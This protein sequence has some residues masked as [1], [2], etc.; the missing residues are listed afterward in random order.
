M[1][2]LHL[3]AKPGCD[4]VDAEEVI[5]FLSEKE[6]SATGYQEALLFLSAKTEISGRLFKKYTT[7]GVKACSIPCE[8]QLILLA[9][10]I[11]HK[12]LS[13]LDLD[14]PYKLKLCNS[15][16]K[17]LENISLRGGEFAEPIQQLLKSTEEKLANLVMSNKFDVVESKSIFD[18]KEI[19]DF[20]TLPITVLFWEGP[21]ARAYLATMYGCGYKPKKILNLISSVDLATKKP[22]AKYTPKIL[23]TIIC[24]F[25]HKIK[26]H[27]W[28][29]NIRKQNN[30]IFSDFRNAI[31]AT[32][33][34][35]SKIYN[36]AYNYKPLA[37]YSEDVV[38]L[39]ITD[40][41]D[42]V[43]GKVIAEEK[44]LFLFTGGGIVPKSLLALEEVKMLHVHPG[45]LPQIRGADCTI[46]SH[47]IAGQPSASMFFLAPGIDDGDVVWGDFLPPCK[48][49]FD[50]KNIDQKTAYRAIFS[51]FDPWVRA[52]I[53]KAGIEKTN[54][55][56][57]IASYPQ[58]HNESKTF[59]FMHKKIIHISLERVFN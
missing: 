14:Y 59:Y 19:S 36:D 18:S 9:A 2:D 15:I 6:T 55:F 21:I 3:I 22:V 8:P 28:S 41:K 47:L 12:N 49:S 44:G 51:Y 35:S 50:L 13:S 17:M 5:E 42:P 52:A 54:G 31:V 32:F 11:L 30:N 33:K 23:K 57:K 25:S 39:L 43:L 34:V 29:E 7:N 26:S 4:Y 10:T 37:E 58:R 46:W 16:F 53:L 1:F 56:S 40:L 27:Y 38:D 20:I 45:K 24:K 48:F